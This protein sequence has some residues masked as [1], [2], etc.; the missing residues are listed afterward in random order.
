MKTIVLGKVAGLALVM[1]VF[2]GLA[3][4]DKEIH[5]GQ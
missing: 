3:G 1:A 2:G 4:R 5:V